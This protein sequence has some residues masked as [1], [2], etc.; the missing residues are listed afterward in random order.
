[1]VTLTIDNRQ[2]QVPEGTTILEAAQTAGIQIP[3]LCYLKDIN[4]IAACRVCCVE[5]KGE[6]AMVTACN[7]FV[8]EGMAVH[9]NSPRARKTRRTNVELILSQVPYWRAFPQRFWTDVFF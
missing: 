8:K 1:M 4:E 3:H 6:R 9:T 5:V 7:S 2:I